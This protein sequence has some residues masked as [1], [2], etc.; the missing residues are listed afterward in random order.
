MASRVS[1]NLDRSFLGRLKAHV[2]ELSVKIHIYSKTL[3]RGTFFKWN[4][5]QRATLSGQ[6][7]PIFH[8]ISSR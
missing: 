4:L 5:R 3:L 8:R 6:Q 1:G 7:T 2:S